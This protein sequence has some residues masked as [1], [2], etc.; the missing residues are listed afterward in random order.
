MQILIIGAGAMGCYFGAALSTS[1]FP[2]TFFDTDQNKVDL[3]NREGL[4]LT[5]LD[6]TEKKL[7]VKA[8]ALIE[9]APPPDLAL[10]MVKAYSTSQAARELSLV[11]TAD[12]QALT[13]QNGL[14]NVGRLSQYLD[15]KQIFSGVT[16]QAALE[17][18][19]G[20]VRH[21]GSGL[22]TL[23]PLLKSSLAAAMEVARLLNNCQL[24]A[25]ATTDI[26]A[27]RWKKLIVNSAI[28]PLSAIHKLANGQLPKNPEIVHDMM[29]L[30]LEGVAVA[31]KEGV[32]LNYGE[33]WA[34]VLDTCRT[35]AQNH[36]S[37]LADVEKGSMTEIE[38]ING[39]IVRLGERHG[40]DTPLNARMVR[41]VVAIH[42]KKD[43]M[44]INV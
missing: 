40:V 19:P 25:A 16:Y 35:T 17:T 4:L 28:N 7:P 2:V 8:I 33:M 44:H 10:V 36:S 11:K 12:T 29:G 14:G 38:A 6:G 21:S 27:I 31:Q 15:E 43:T 30:V 20:Q 18:A 42:G 34:S 24:P 37:M 9:D 1:G 13:L 32:P 5:E 22:T 3:L 23:S 39:S 26:K 41:N